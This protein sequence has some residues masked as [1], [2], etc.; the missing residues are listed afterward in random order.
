LDVQK[1]IEITKS[2]FPN[3]RETRYYESSHYQL[4][5]QPTH[6]KFTKQLLKVSHPSSKPVVLYPIKVKTTQSVRMKTRTKF[7]NSLQTT[8]PDNRPTARVVECL[9][10]AESEVGTHPSAT[11]RPL[12]SSISTNSRSSGRKSIVSFEREPDDEEY[13]E[14]SRLA[15]KTIVDRTKEDAACIYEI[16]RPI[17]SLEQIGDEVLFLMCLLGSMVKFKSGS[18]LAT[19]DHFHEHF[20]VVLKGHVQVRKM[21]RL[22][23]QRSSLSLHSAGSSQYSGR[24]ASSLIQMSSHV[25][26]LSEKETVGSLDPRKFHSRKEYAIALEPTIVYR[27]DVTEIYRLQ[28]YVNEKNQQKTMVYLNSLDLCSKLRPEQKLVLANVSNIHIDD[29]IAQLSQGLTNRCTR[30]KF[31]SN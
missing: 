7:E 1:I 22:R 15:E 2:V 14:M 24:S 27:I 31:Q 5:D 30:P 4:L 23:N 18:L 20:Y 17:P 28:K 12:S 11:P 6:S 29:P 16:L 8:E 10:V 19:P 21:E 26:Y 9:P 3:E 13:K 25:A